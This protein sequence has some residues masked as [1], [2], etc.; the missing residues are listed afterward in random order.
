MMPLD[1]GTGTSRPGYQGVMLSEVVG[2]PKLLDSVE[3]GQ[4]IREQLPGRLVRI[5]ATKSRLPAP[6]PAGAQRPGPRVGLESDGRFP[7]KVRP[8]A[9]RGS[10]ASL[11][12][13]SPSCPC[14]RKSPLGEKMG[15]DVHR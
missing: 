14:W 9:T 4:L 12:R 15:A 3:R 11:L 7:W 1:V 5:A 10:V 6:A 8:I 13:G 2:A